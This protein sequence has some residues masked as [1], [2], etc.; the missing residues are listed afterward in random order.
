MN[1][2][3][4]TLM[5]L[6]V[7][8][9]IIAG[10]AAVTYPSYKSSI[11]RAR[12]SEAV[13]MVGTIQASQQKHF[14]NY[15]SYGTTF[16]DINDF[17][18]VLQILLDKLTIKESIQNKGLYSLK[19]YQNKSFVMT[20]DNLINFKGNIIGSRDSD[21]YFRD[22]N[23]KLIIGGNDIKTGEFNNGYSDLNDFVK[24]IGAKIEYKWINQDCITLDEIPYIGRLSMFSDNL[25]VATG[26]NLWG[27]TG[28][29]QSALLI[30]DLI[31]NNTNKY[32]KLFSPSRICKFKPLFNNISNSIINLFKIN[33]HRCNHLGCSLVCDDKNDTLECPCHGSK[34]YKNGELIDG[35]AIDDLK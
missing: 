29:M 30:K 4:F 6:L 3:G 31:C 10:F 32:E 21:L 5:E 34:Y 7:V 17:E 33:K 11:E 24:S 18:T 26:F 27:M 13:T 23:G 15:E 12:A 1:K 9:V 8:V 2:K 28:A 20:C 19:M 35:P 22:Y 25:Y 14:I 16:Q